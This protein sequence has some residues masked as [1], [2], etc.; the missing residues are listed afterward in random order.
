MGAVS[1]QLHMLGRSSV[2]GSLFSVIIDRSPTPEQA[3]PGGKPP[4]GTKGFGTLAR[5]SSPL[6]HF[7][8]LLVSFLKRRLNV[9]FK[10]SSLSSSSADSAFRLN[11]SEWKRLH[12]VCRLY[13]LAMSALLECKT[14]LLSG[15]NEYP[16]LAVLYCK[17]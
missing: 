4:D 11:S 5:R 14:D 8:I 6:L 12:A 9:V 2:I 17:C 7:L 1:K 16:R 15:K 10:F 3:S 13:E